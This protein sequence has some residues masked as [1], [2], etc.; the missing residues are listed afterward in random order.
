MVATQPSVAQ[1]EDTLSSLQDPIPSVWTDQLESSFNL[2]DGG[3]GRLTQIDA[4]YV[5]VYS[6]SDVGTA[7]WILDSSNLQNP[8][9]ANVPANE[10]LALV[11]GDPSQRGRYLNQ[12]EYDAQVPGRIVQGTAVIEKLSPTGEVVT[13]YRRETTETAGG[14]FADP[15]ELNYATVTLNDGIY[16]VSAEGSDF[17]YLIKVGD[18]TP[19][20]DD[21]LK[22]I[23][24]TL[25][26]GAQAIKDQLNSGALQ[27]VTTTTN[28]TGYYSLDVPSNAKV[29]TVTARKAPNIPIDPQ[30]LTEQS[31]RDY[32]EVDAETLEDLNE[33]Q[34]QQSLEAIEK[35]Q[36]TTIYSPSAPVTVRPPKQ[37]V[38][39]TLLEVSYPQYGNLTAFQEQLGLLDSLFNNESFSE[40]PSAL[41]QRIEDLTRTQREDLYEELFDLRTQNDKLQERYKDLLGDDAVGIDLNET[42][43]AEL[44]ERISK[45]QQSLSELQS[46]I[47]TGEETVERA[48]DTVTWSQEFLDVGL[49]LENVIVKAHYTNGTSQVISDEYIN[50]ESSPGTAA[51]FGSSTVTVEEYPMP[52]DVAG[53]RFDVTVANGDGIGK[54]SSSSVSNPAYDGEVPSLSSVSMSTLSPGPSDTLSMRLNPGE[55]SSFK[56]VV[57]AEAYGPNGQ[58]LATTV[59]NSTGEV[60]FQT[61]GQGVH[62]ARLTFEDFEGRQHVLPVRVKAASADRDRPTGIRAVETPF[63]TIAQVGDGL[64]SGAVDVDS[65]GAVSFTAQVGQGDDVPNVVH[66]YDSGLSVSSDS[67]RTV[68]VVRGDDRESVNRHVEVVYHTAA[69]NDNALLYRGDSQPITRDASTR[70]GEVSGS[71]SSTTISSWTDADGELSLRINNNPGTLDRVRHWIAV[72][73]A[74][75]NVP[76]VGTVA[77]RATAAVP[78]DMT[79]ALG[80]TAGGSAVAV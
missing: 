28:A 32:Y 56:S 46:S 63:G 57:S 75:I 50:I 35:L 67:T 64:E 23:N 5:G 12:H 18:P 71:S 27:R 77:V 69:L 22:T 14:G 26:D 74:D 60:T 3:A 59:N 33:Q 8:M 51:G 43:D 54:A 7:P 37:N 10:E 11:V 65:S 16:R 17:S 80:S 24:G 30:N 39:I 78:A 41:Q 9:W 66:V 58:T 45:L 79:P 2:Y 42:S 72:R 40:L 6:E 20:L 68:R 62:T 38:D 34:T 49:D 73:T 19:S 31:I 1:A 55:D 25:T 53:V 4:Q 47:E 48:S 44:R 52:S 36:N 15:S 21:A 76:F 61:G 13:T 29:V 70:F